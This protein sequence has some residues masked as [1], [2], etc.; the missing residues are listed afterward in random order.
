MIVYT[1]LQCHYRKETGEGC[2]SLSSFAEER[3]E[4][5]GERMG[6]SF[7]QKQEMD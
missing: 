1:M 3:R 5:Y 6:E 4:R 7:L 2:L